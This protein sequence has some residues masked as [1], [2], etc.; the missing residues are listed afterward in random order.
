MVMFK[1]IHKILNCSKTKKQQ[2]YLNLNLNE[3]KLIKI[4][5]KINFINKIFLIKNNFYKIELNVESPINIKLISKPSNKLFLKASQ[6]K[7]INFSKKIIFIST[8]KGIL[9]NFECE[10]LNIG[11]LLLFAIFK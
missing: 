6:L 5:I 7:K 3:I 8:S 11:G 1:T 2:L 10:K 4:L 9:S